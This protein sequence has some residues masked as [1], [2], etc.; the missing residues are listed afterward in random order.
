MVSH[1]K[2]KA[3]IAV[4]II[5]TSLHYRAGA[6]R[7]TLD[8]VNTPISFGAMYTMYRYLDT[9]PAV[10]KTIM[11]NLM[12]IMVLSGIISTLHVFVWSFMVN[13]LHQTTKHLVDDHSTLMCSLTEA[14]PPFLMFAMTVFF[15]QISKLYLVLFPHSFFN[16]NHEL[17][18]KVSICLIV[19]T[20][21]SEILFCVG[22]N[23]HYCLKPHFNII[24]YQ[25]NIQA[26]A[27]TIQI[28]PWLGIQM[29]VGVL[30]EI[31]SNTVLQYRAWKQRRTT[32]PAPHLQP[33]VV[34]VN[35]PNIQA[36]VSNALPLN[37]EPQNSKEQTITKNFTL[38][39]CA[40]VFS[41][42]WLN[43]IMDFTESTEMVK[44][45]SLTLTLVFFQV[46]RNLVPLV[47]L[48]SC[49]ETIEFASRLFKDKILLCPTVIQNMVSRFV[50]LELMD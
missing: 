30:A 5:L 37:Q 1:I 44:N 29:V 39:V 12:K 40:L 23:G 11:N 36:P 28:F 15:L 8:S 16:F 17:G 38:I 45:V 4:Y 46:A 43:I 24:A 13:V 18:T 2:L 26:E 14:R 21:V 27:S 41:L 50:N 47:W 49:D 22:L 32:A 33:F 19:L 34:S 3:C 7:F 25:L 20:L 42:I 35:G 9:R 48:T 6:L 10:H 31:T